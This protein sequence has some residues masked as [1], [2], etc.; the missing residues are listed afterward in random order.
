MKISMIYWWQ[1]SQILLEVTVIFCLPLWWKDTH[2]FWLQVMSFFSS[3]LS[4]YCLWVLSMNPS[5]KGVGQKS[6][7]WLIHELQAGRIR[8]QHSC[9]MSFKPHQ[10]PFPPSCPHVLSLWWAWLLLLTL[11][12][13]EHVHVIYSWIYPAHLLG[14][15]CMARAVSSLGIW[16][17]KDTMFK[18]QKL[19]TF[20][21]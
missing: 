19:Q 15:Y 1:K 4:L 18:H 21:S 3:H 12:L 14:A 16:T 8:H 13:F 10:L 5:L 9:R 17:I 11:H 20:F 6:I 7:Q 2:A